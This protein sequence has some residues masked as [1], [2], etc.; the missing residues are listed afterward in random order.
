VKQVY[1]KGAKQVNENVAPERGEALFA[2]LKELRK[3]YAMKAGVPAYVIFTDAALHD[4]VRKQPKSVEDFL[5]VSG[6]GK[7][8]AEKYGTAF[9]EAIADFSTQMD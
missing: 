4:M 7:V 3:Q 1:E 6:V 5:D 8:K 2:H 9:V